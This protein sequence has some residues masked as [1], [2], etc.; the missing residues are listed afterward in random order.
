MLFVVLPC[1]PLGNAPVRRFGPVSLNGVSNVTYGPTGD[2]Y[3]AAC[4][5]S[6]DDV[7]L[8]VMLCLLLPP[9]ERCAR[10]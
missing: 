2:S 3:I 7:E 6:T 8:Q 9:C 5:V 10:P 1:V 4:S